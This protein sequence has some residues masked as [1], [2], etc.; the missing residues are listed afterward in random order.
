[1]IGKAGIVLAMVYKT[2]MW[3]LYVTVLSILG[4]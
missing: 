3:Y 4:I 2:A 1:V